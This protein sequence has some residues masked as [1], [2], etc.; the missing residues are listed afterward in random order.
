[1]KSRVAKAVKLLAVAITTGACSHTNHTNAPLSTAS[2]TLS[3]SPPQVQSARSAAVTVDQSAAAGFPTV[4]PEQRSTLH[5][6]VRE[7]AKDRHSR[8]ALETMKAD[9]TRF[10]PLCDEDGYPLVGNVSPGKGT[11]GIAVSD[12]CRHARKLEGK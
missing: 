5:G 7:L 10:R 3:A 1:M 9:V 6:L 8:S 2:A 11:K 12:F 4:T